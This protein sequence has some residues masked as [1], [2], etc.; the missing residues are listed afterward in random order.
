MGQ[1]STSEQDQSTYEITTDSSEFNQIATPITPIASTFT[2]PYTALTISQVWNLQ[3]SQEVLENMKKISR[4]ELEKIEKKV[5]FTKA[6]ASFERDVS[7]PSTDDGGVDAQLIAYEDLRWFVMVND[8]EN[9]YDADDQHDMILKGKPF[10][11][12]L[13]VIIS[14]FSIFFFLFSIIPLS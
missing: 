13:A 12:F 10:F 2:Q 8:C 14:F 4:E 1:D 5:N 6:M 7:S 11:R 9:T 3:T